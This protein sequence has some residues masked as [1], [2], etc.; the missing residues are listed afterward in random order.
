MALERKPIGYWEHFENAAREARE[1][2]E[3]E[4]WDRLPSQS[5][6]ADKGYH[7][8][9]NGINRHHGGLDAFRESLGQDS[10]RKRIGYWEDVDVTLLEAREA[11][12][13]HGWELLPADHV[14]REHGYSSLTTAIDK[15]HGGMRKFRKLLGERQRERP[16]GSLEDLDYVVDMAREVMIPEDG[17]VLP[18]ASILEERQYSSLCYAIMKYHGGFDTFRRILEERGISPSPQQELEGLLGGYGD[19]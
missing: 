3:S 14:L 11:M 10:S 2:M 18:P 12:A 19:E 8:L 16:K 9:L 7:G 4:E 5:V 15:Y 13:E 1:A 17:R 6:L